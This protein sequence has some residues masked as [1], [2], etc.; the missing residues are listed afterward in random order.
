MNF[1]LIGV[2]YQSAPPE[3]RQRLY[4]AR[5]QIESFWS[6]IAALDTAILVTCNRFDISI[7]AR[8]DKEFAASLEWFNK[9]FPEFYAY[10]Y[11]K[12]SSLKVLRYGLRLACGLESQLK[13]EF[14]ILEQ[15]G[16]WLK[17]GR[18]PQNLFEFWSRIIK[19]ASEIRFESGLSSQEINIAKLLFED[20]KNLY[21][22]HGKL[23]MAIVGTG[24]LAALLVE[25]RPEN[26]CLSFVARKNRFKAEVLANRVDGKV[27]SLNQLKA[28][29]ANIDVLVS[30]AASP[31]IILKSGD[32][33]DSVSSRDK[34]LYIYDLGFP[35]NVAKEL[36]Y[37]K[38]I[39][40]K[41]LDDLVLSV[42][43]TNNYLQGNF[44]LAEYLIEE[45]V[46]QIDYAQSW[47]TAQ[48]AS[49]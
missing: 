19:A 40:L 33:P 38:N 49:C 43:N 17:Q 39:I 24:K 6:G 28:A 15:L 34:P 42:K 26:V 20:L 21:V 14:Q 16:V 11:V 37:R 22:S 46:K 3:I 9:E 32:I 7:A 23:E 8:T 36:G 10:S 30:A 45:R 18:F 31:H 35:M 5:R 4:R 25:Y 12:E 27:L 47:N 41:N 2:D 1:Y 29:V 48:S 44:N 13:G